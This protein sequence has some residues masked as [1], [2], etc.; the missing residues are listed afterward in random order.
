MSTLSLRLAVAERC[1]NGQKP[2]K[3]GRRPPYAVQDMKP[4]GQMARLI[5]RAS[6]T[7]GENTRTNFREYRS[8]A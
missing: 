3:V 2:D 5:C 1:Q 4:I 8:I 6:Y 7:Y